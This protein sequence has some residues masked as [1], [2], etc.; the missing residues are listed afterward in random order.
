MIKNNVKTKKAQ[1]AKPT[2]AQIIAELNHARCVFQ[3]AAI[4]C[5]M[6]G[7]L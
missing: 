5:V 7:E 1:S 6:K 3:L 2:N 4:C